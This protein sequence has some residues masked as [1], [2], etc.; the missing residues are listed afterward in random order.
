[1]EE[2]TN[3]ERAK[4]IL[5]ELGAF[6]VPNPIVLKAIAMRRLMDSGAS[7]A[8]AHKAIEQAMME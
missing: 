3:K 4:R 2:V 1:M 5:K 7:D 8:E 6:E